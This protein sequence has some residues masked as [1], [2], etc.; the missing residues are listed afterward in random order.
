VQKVGIA[1]PL[2][3]GICAKSRHNGS[4]KV[5]DSV[6]PRYGGMVWFDNDSEN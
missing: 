4:T 3:L 5:L 1:G 6:V 2:R